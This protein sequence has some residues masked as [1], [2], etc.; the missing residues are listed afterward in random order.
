MSNFVATWQDFPAA[1]LLDSELQVQDL[2]VFLSASL[3][4]EN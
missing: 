4:G 2:R 3:T 1:L